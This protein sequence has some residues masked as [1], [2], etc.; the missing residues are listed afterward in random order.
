M[1]GTRGNDESNCVDEEEGKKEVLSR[2]LSTTMR[3][4]PA[5]DRRKRDELRL[6]GSTP[7]QAR[8]SHGTKALGLDDT[9]RV[10]YGHYGTR[11]VVGST[12]TG[13]FGDG[14]RAEAR[15]S[16]AATVARL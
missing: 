13:R 1:S 16:H 11:A 4:D 8:I 3:R 9:S 2:P 5:V 12:G 7:S 10:E 6:R 15:L 14:A